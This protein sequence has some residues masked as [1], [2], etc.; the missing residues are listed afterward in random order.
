MDTHA[1]RS[2]STSGSRRSTRTRSN[3]SRCALRALAVAA[4]ACK[5]RSREVIRANT[6]APPATVAAPAIG[7]AVDVPAGDSATF[8]SRE[9]LGAT[10]RSRSPTITG[11]RRHGARDLPGCRRRARVSLASNSLHKIGSALQP[12]FVVDREIDARTCAPRG[13]RRSRTLRP[14]TRRRRLDE[15][16]TGDGVGGETSPAARRRR[17]R[18]FSG[19]SRIGWWVG[20][21]G[22][23]LGR[24]AIRGIRA[25][26]RAEVERC[27]GGAILDHNREGDAGLSDGI[28]RTRSET[29]DQKLVC[30]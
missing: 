6:A 19:L 27:R 21:S 13:S 22:V 17:S 9:Y 25:G 15:L 5:G 14:R 8:D 7:N 18:W 24:H 1:P 26:H 12:P 29:R 2:T 4:S 11:W 28:R 20:R 30:R 3:A 10:L 16:A 23:G